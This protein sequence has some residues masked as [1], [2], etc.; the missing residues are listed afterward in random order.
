MLLDNLLGVSC[1]PHKVLCYIP[2]AVGK[3]LKKDLVK[4]VFEGLTDQL[5]EDNSGDE[6]E[7]CDQLEDEI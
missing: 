4:D 7:D 2:G 1:A 6:Q 5:Q 3:K